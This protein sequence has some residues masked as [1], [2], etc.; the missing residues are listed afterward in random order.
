MH[1]WKALSHVWHFATPWT[2]HNSPWNSP[3][4]NTGV[5]SSS[6]LQGI[7]PT[8]GSNPGLPHLGQILY[9]L[10]HQGSPLTH[11]YMTTR[12]S[13]SLSKLWELVTDREAWCAGVHGVTESWTRLSNRIELNSYTGRVPLFK[14]FS[15]NMNFC[16]FQILKQLLIGACHFWVNFKPTKV[17][18]TH[19]KI[20]MAKN[21]SVSTIAACLPYALK[22]D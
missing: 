19:S 3:G 10:S 2:I 4:Q 6:L 22:V 7:F 16:I 13:M 14:K 15:H 20:I 1:R 18:G 12:K 9:Q 17:D 11:P 8:Q 21:I 5:G